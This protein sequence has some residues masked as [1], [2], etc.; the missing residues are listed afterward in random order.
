VSA[1][2][3]HGFLLSADTFTTI[4]VPGASFTSGLEINARGDIIGFFTMAGV[5][6]GFLLIH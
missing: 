6:H 1:G 4:D 2:I 5:N 3:S